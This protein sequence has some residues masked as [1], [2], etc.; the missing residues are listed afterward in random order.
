MAR[1]KVVVFEPEDAIRRLIEII[2]SER[3]DVEST[4]LTEQH[5]DCDLLLVDISVPYE[6]TIS[7]LGRVRSTTSAP[8]VAMSASI[9]DSVRYAAMQ[10]GA[11][12]FL[13][14]PFDPDRLLDCVRHL[15][16]DQAGPASAGTSQRMGTLE[17]DFSRS[18]VSVNGKRVRLSYS[19]WLILKS[20]ASAPG[21][22]CM[23]GELLTTVWGAAVKYDHRFLELWI[24]RIRSKLGCD[25]ANPRLIRPYHDIGYVLAA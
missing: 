21:Q 7:E 2:L 11:D 25:P 15:L 23:H 16:E 24:N 1:M 6:K 9:D 13:V 3:Y 14:Q 10:A 19:E 20:L 17:V 4:D 8:L 12:D 5:P 22:P 18:S